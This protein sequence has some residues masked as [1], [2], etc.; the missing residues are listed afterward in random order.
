MSRMP[1]NLNIMEVNKMANIKD[2]DG[3]KVFVHSVGG[4]DYSFNVDSFPADKYDWLCKVV[5]NHMDDIHERASTKADELAKAKIR[6]AL[7][8]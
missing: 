2:Y 4:H 7:G 1:F 6:E 8:L 3:A 5:G